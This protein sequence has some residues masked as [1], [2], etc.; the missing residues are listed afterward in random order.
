VADNMPAVL[1][2][3]LNVYAGDDR[4]FLLEL[5]DSNDDPIDLTG[6]EFSAQWRKTR[7][8]DSAFD[9]V[10]EDTDLDSGTITLL[11]SGAISA[12]IADTTTKDSI[13]GVWD[14]QGVRDEET[15]T[16]ITG[17]M[18]IGKDVTRG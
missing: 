3:A 6:Y 5:L 9:L 2:Q 14:I 13:T 15:T 17:S 16:F 7:S 8:S 4:S 10:V 11:V 12:E 18:K 1:A